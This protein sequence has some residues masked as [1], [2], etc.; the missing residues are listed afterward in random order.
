MYDL[1]R[2]RLLSELRNRGSLAAVA[3]AL[4]YNPSSV[5]HQLSILKREVGVDVLETSGRSVRLTA[6]GEL[7]ADSAERILQEMEKTQ[8]AVATLAREPS[9]RI[10]VAAFQTA[11]HSLLPSVISNLQ[12]LH[13]KLHILFRQLPAEQALSAL[14]AQ[15]FDLVLC[16]EYPGNPLSPN[17]GIH[18]ELLT[19]DPLWLATPSHSKVTDI[20]DCADLDWVMEPQGTPARTWA[21]NHCRNAGFEPKVVYETS[22]VYAHVQYVKEGL[23]AAF[24]PELVLPAG[25]RHVATREKRNLLM[26]M[27]I[28]SQDSPALKALRMSLA[29]KSN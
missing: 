8:A 5:S 15:D 17:P 24:I 26:A 6:A 29:S 28:G 18:M 3:E 9:G 23:A 12:G 25:H 22:D 19:Q 21:V 1:H 2:L 27:R 10:R 11:A 7:L 16:E 20:A 14:M 4:G 13:P